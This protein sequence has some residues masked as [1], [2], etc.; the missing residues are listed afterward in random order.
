MPP[1]SLTASSITE[2]SSG[3]CWRTR[4][5]EMD[6]DL[7]LY[8]MDGLED[9]QEQATGQPPLWV[10]SASQRAGTG[11]PLP[12]VMSTVA[13]QQLLTLGPAFT[14]H[15]IC[16]A[17]AGSVCGVLQCCGHDCE[18]MPRESEIRRM[19]RSAQ[20]PVLLH[21]YE[22]GNAK[23]VQHVNQVTMNILRRGGIFH[24]AIEVHGVE[25]SYGGTMDWSTGVY[26]CE[27]RMN[28]DHTF[29][30][31]VYLG[32]CRKGQ[33]EVELIVAR[34]AAEWLGMQ[35][36]LLHQNCC[37]FSDTLAHELGV[38][39]IPRWVNRLARRGAFFDDEA[40]FMQAHFFKKPT[41]PQGAADVA[42]AKY[43]RWHEQWMKPKYSDKL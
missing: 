25:W 24:G 27:P 11:R 22:V 17:P 6:Q 5:G 35:Y 26:S 37:H 2:T 15:R 43:G 30:E 32:D 10:A 16:L 18:S 14:D 1:S 9:W 12:E 8:Q 3:P 40:E 28:P 23:T 42:L 19:V 20:T 34:M 39:G 21:V 29:R 41:R 38:G 7:Q 36:S 4:H 31:S 13:P 33:A